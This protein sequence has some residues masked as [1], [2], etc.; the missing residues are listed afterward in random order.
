MI[1]VKHKAQPKLL[2][3][4]YYKRLEDNDNSDSETETL[5]QI[6]ELRESKEDNDPITDKESKEELICFLNEDNKKR[7]YDLL[8]PLFKESIMDLPYDKNIDDNLL[9]IYKEYRNKKR[10][11]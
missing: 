8:L 5:S 10:R 11:L 7:K 9:K 4:P 1:K 6:E 3:S 2:I